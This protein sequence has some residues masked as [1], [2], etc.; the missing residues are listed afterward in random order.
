MAKALLGHVGNNADLRLVA[1]VG[2]LRSRVSE[3]EGE[4]ARMR[5][6]NDAL[7][8]SVT[9]DDDLRMLTLTE[10]HALT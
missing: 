4:L 6:V 1:E 5:A 2:R 3:L 8:A 10:E 7:A 9:V